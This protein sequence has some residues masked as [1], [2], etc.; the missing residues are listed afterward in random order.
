MPDE[1]LTRSSHCY[2]GPVGGMI[3]IIIVNNNNDNHNA[4]L[5]KNDLL[6]DVQTSFDKGRSCLP[7]L[8]DVC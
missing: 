1:Q 3:R 7:C 2:G 5:R 4:H 6:G 8:L